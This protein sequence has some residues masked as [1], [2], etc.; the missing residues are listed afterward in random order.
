MSLTNETHPP[1]M[2]DEPRL[3]AWQRW[4]EWPLTGLAVLFL[5][6]YAVEV[7]YV[8]APPTARDRLAVTLWII[9]ALF[10]ADYVVR[11]LLAVHKVRFLLHTPFDLAVVALPML[12][13]LRA[14]RLVAAVTVI[15]R[16]LM[17]SVHRRVAAYTTGATT[18]V[19]LAA[20]LAVLDAERDAPG[21]SI[22]TFAD[23]AW[24]TLT[25]ITTVGYGDR[26]PITGEGRLVAA[27]LMIGGIA[28]LGVVT[29]L[30]ASWFVRM[31]EGSAQHADETARELA[32]LR[33][34]LRAAVDCSRASGVR[35][36][37]FTDERPR[38]V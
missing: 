16:R 29:G 36:E 15:N 12:R 3:R 18:L 30:I 5:A 21:A 34:E 22:T 14:L 26:Y 13:P 35:G 11:F 7:L 20:S 33:R 8:S 24:W 31:I 10:I 19:G 25:T 6:C 38:S 2:A 4:T 37:A 17:R 28:L 32:E 23:A 27:T 1:W 9:W